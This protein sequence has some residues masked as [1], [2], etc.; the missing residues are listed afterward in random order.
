MN[1]DI[2]LLIFTIGHG[3]FDNSM[4]SRK[5]DFHHISTA[6]DHGGN[7]QRMK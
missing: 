5:W 2:Q 6:R 7:N 3:S 1:K 4:G